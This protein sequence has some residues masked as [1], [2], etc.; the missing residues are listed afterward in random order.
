VTVLGLVGATVIQL[1]SETGEIGRFIVTETGDLLYGEALQPGGETLASKRIPS[2]GS[3]R[4]ERLQDLLV[5]AR[6]QGTGH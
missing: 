2:A 3:R 4:D 5:L 1:Q 6:N